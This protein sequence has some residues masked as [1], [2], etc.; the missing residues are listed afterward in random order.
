M[1]DLLKE[2]HIC[3]FSPTKME[4]VKKKRELLSLIR[5]YRFVREEELIFH[6]Q[7]NMKEVQ[8]SCQKVELSEKIKMLLRELQKNDIEFWTIQRVSYPCG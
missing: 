2:N 7:K 3:L 8:S 6:I 5:E 1:V 4:Q